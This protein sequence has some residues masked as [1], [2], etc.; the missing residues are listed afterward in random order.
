[1]RVTNAS[2]IWLSKR[3]L[4]EIYGDNN[5][6]DLPARTEQRLENH[7]DRFG[8]SVAVYSMAGVSRAIRNPS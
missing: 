8:E 5:A 7:A 4:C 2:S 3:S 6:A 1:M